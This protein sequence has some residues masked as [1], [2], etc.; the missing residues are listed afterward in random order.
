MKDIILINR[1]TCQDYLGSVICHLDHIYSV[2]V[3]D[4]EYTMVEYEMLAELWPRHT[5]SKDRT[6]KHYLLL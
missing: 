4:T 3:R 6:A 2:W 1:R 5:V